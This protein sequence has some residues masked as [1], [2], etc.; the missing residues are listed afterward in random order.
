MPNGESER[1]VVTCSSCGS[2]Y[3]AERWSDGTIQPIGKRTGCDCG[4]EKFY[5]VEDSDSPVLQDEEID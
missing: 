1:T 3:A 2:V 4:S 5:V